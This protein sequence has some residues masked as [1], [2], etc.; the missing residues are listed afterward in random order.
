[1]NPYKKAA[2]LLIRLIA[3][4]LMLFGVINIALYLLKSFLNK[5][6]VPTGLCLLMGIPIV[7]G[8]AIMV[9]SSAIAG[10]LTQDFDE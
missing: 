4:G 3:S 10:R 6:D 5:A 1:M 9:K 8:L 7:M 2:L